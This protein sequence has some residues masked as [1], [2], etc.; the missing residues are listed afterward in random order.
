[1]IT[2]FLRTAGRHGLRNVRNPSRISAEADGKFRLYRYSFTTQS[3]YDQFVGFVNGLIDEKVPCAF[4]RLELSAETDDRL[5]ITAR[6]LFTTL[7]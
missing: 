7:Q 2:A 3:S 5:A 6:L 1:M 4:E